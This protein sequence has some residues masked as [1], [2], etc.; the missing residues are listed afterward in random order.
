MSVYFNN[1]DRAI[2]FTLA[3]SDYFN[4]SLTEAEINDRLPKVWDWQFFTG[5]KLS[6]SELKI[7]RDKTEIKTSLDK[8]LKAKKIKKLEIDGHKYYFLNNRQKLVELKI[9]RKKIAKKREEAIEDF[10]NLVR[11]LPSIKAVIL[12]GSSA[13]NNAEIN[14]DLDF[15]LITRKNTLWITRF[16]LIFMAK[17]LGKRPQIDAQS[18][19]DSK[20]AWCFNLWLDESSLRI[21][22]RNFSIYQAYEVKQMR[23]LIVNKNLKALFLFKN[24]QLSELLELNLNKMSVKKQKNSFLD[25]FFWP[26]NLFFY[27]FQNAYR[28]L[29]FGKENYFL[30]P[31]QAHFN[32]ANRQEDIFLA[33]KQKMKEN[34][35]F[36]L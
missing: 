18:K 20:Q 9:A 32:E 14:D 11:F 36:T 17:V 4:F 8:L 23:W 15:C 27:F 13:V 25:Y 28:Y 1:L 26:I 7:D 35:L 29:F 30:S 19:S 21:I 2:F 6:S 12:T 16:I 5:Q 3:Y 24:K 22:N 33:I 10:L 34:G 31:Y